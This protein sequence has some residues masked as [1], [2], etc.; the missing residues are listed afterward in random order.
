[1]IQATNLCKEFRIK[2]S[3]DVSLKNVKS[4]FFPEY[5]IFY[6]VKNLSFSIQRGEKVAFLGANGAGKSTAIKMLTGILYPTSGDI[7]VNGLIPWKERSKLSYNIGIVF[8][9]RSQLW[10]YLPAKDTYQL[11]SKIYGLSESRYKQRLEEIAEVLKITNIIEIPVNQLSL[12]QR[13]RCEIAATLLHRPDILFLDEPTIGIDINT[14]MAIRNYLNILS[15]QEGTTILLTSHDIADIEQVCNKVIIL[16]EGKKI[17]DQS[18][19]SIKEHYIK[20]KRIILKTQDEIKTLEITGVKIVDTLSTTVT[21]EVDN[22]TISTQK[23][24]GILLSRYSVSD[25]SIVDPPLEEIIQNIFNR[26][27]SRHAF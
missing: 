22:Q 12:G 26:Q 21:L 23:V 25:I 20:V 5:T 27:D 19:D 1:M 11:I 3:A 10:A 16:N 9:Q 18:L 13:M 2:K 4:L 17:I 7:L 6:A 14:K 24:I 8:G 15:E